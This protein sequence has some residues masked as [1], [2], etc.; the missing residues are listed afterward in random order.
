[1]HTS[2]FEVKI[3]HVQVLSQLHD[4]HLY[5]LIRKIFSSNFEFILTT[6]MWQDNSITKEYNNNEC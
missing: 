3:R 1:M 5:C 6:N 2:I 4:I